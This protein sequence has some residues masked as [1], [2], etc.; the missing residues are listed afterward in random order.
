MGAGVFLKAI[1]QSGVLSERVTGIEL[2][3]SLGEWRESF[4]QRLYGV[5]A[6]SWMLDSGKSFDA[7]VGN[8][9]YTSLSFVGDE[10][11]AAVRSLC[12]LDGKPIRLSGNLWSTFLLASL[13]VLKP[14]GS[15]AFVL[16]AAW[17]YADYANCLRQQL[18]SRFETFHV[19]RSAR[20]LFPSV[21][22]GSVVILG[23]GYGLEHRYASRVNCRDLASVCSALSDFKVGERPV[24]ASQG[25]D[26]R[27]RSGVCLDGY[28]DIRLGGVTGDSKYFTLSERDRLS[29]GIPAFACRKIVSRSRH[30]RWPSIGKSEW[31]DLRDA[32]EKVWLFRPTPSALSHPNVANY[33]SRSASEGGCDR[34]RFKISRRHPWYVTPLP[35]RAD[36]FISGMS[37]RG[38]MIVFNNMPSLSATNTLYV[39]RFHKELSSGQQ[40]NLALQLLNG[41]IGEQL[42]KLQR[43]YAGG[44]KKFEPGDLLKLRVEEPTR[45]VSA[46]EYAREFEAFAARSGA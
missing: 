41:R 29:F 44:M 27:A 17:D 23:T 12:G 33:L 16:P 34:E 39:V 18:P 19:F 24:S 15:M 1:E 22:E 6:I 37:G 26:V 30:M 46:R 35:S 8:P 40:R 45:N 7:I 42:W 20:P 4:G 25:D 21:T 14:G 5:E 28:L 36:A 31:E 3:R 38:P 10:V 9:P 13:R 2:D 11:R 43:N 32:G